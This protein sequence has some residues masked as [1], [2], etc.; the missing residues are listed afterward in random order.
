VAGDLFVHLLSG[1]HHVTGSIGPE[2]ILATGGLRYWNDGRDVPDIMFAMLDYG[3]QPSHAEFTVSLRVNL[4][5]GM[6]G[7]VSD[8]GLWGRME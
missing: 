1:L 7:S 6:R 3:K 5:S 4:K 8:S 2:R